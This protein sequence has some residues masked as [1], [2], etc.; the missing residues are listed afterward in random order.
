MKKYVK[1]LLAALLVMTMVATDAL[2]A[3]AAKKASDSH[4]SHI[5]MTGV[6]FSALSEKALE[7]LAKYSADKDVKSAFGKTVEGYNTEALKDTIWNAIFMNRESN[8]IN[9]EALGISQENADALTE[10]VLAESNAEEAVAYSVRK[11]SDGDATVMEVQIDPLYEAAYDEIDAATANTTS[12]EVAAASADDGVMLLTE[13]DDTATDPQEQTMEDAYAAFNKYQQFIDANPDYFGITVPYTSVKDDSNE[14]GGP[15]T[16]LV[17]IANQKVDYNNDGKIDDQDQGVT[18]LDLFKAGFVPASDL[19]QIINMFDM[20][21]QL[22]VNML[23]SELIATKDEA[24]AVVPGDVSAEQKLLILNDWLADKAT[25]DMASIMELDAPEPT[26]P[27]IYTQV[28]GA[29]QQQGLGESDAQALAQQLMGL[30][31]GN[32]FGVLTESMGNKGVCMSYTYAYAYLVQWAFSDVYKNKDGSWK[33]RLELN[34]I[35]N[36]KKET[37]EEI[38]LMAEEAVDETDAHE[39]TYKAK[40]TWSGEGTETSAKADIQCTECE[41]TAAGAYFGEVE[42]KVTAESVGATCASAGKT[43][44]TAT[45]EHETGIYTDKEEVIN[46]NEPAT[47]DH[48][49][50]ETATWS[51][52]DNDTA[53]AVVKCTQCGATKEETVEATKTSTTPSTCTEA[54]KTVYTATVTIDGKEYTNTNEVALELAEHTYSEETDKCTVCGELK[55]DHEHTYGDPVWSDW[56]EE[57]TTTATFT[58]TVCNEEETPENVNV[59]NVVTP[60]T[61]TEAG[62]T[63]YTASVEFGEESYTNPTTH[64]VDGDAATGHTYTEAPVWAWTDD[65]TATATY[66]CATCKEE[67]AVKAEVTSETTATCTEAG[68]TT[69]TATVTV[70]EEAD[71]GTKTVDTPALGHKFDE[72]DKCTV[73]GEKDLPDYVWDPSAAAMV[74][75]VRITY[76]TEVTMYGES[77]GNFDSDH[78][79]NAVKVDGQWYYVDPCYTDIY[80]ECMIRDRVETD[81]NMS[82]LYFMFSDTSARSLYEGNFSGIDTLYAD[83]AKETKY[84]DAW[85]AFARSPICKSGSKYYY[86]YDSTDMISLTSDSFNSYNQDT[87]YRLVYHDGTK[88]DTDAS[89]QTLIDFVEGEVRVVDED[90]KASMKENE[91]IATLYAE[92]EAYQ[93]KYPSIGISCDME[94]N[95]LYFNISNC[96]L[97][98][99][100][101]TCE[102]VKVFEYNEVTAER[103]LSMGLGGMAFT[104]VDPTE[105]AE[106]ETEGAELTT[107]TVENNPIASMTIKNGNMYVS[108]GTTIGFISGKESMSEEDK[109]I[110]YQFEETNYNPEYMEYVMSEGAM[111]EEEENDNDEFMWSANFVD[112]IEMS[113]I[114][115]EHTYEEVYVEA[116]CGKN[117]YTENRCTE[118]G[119]IEAG[120]REEIEDTALEHHFVKFDETYYTKTGDAWNT[121]TCYVCTNCKDAKD[122]DELEDTDHKG[123]AYTGYATAW[124]ED[125]TEATMDV[126]CEACHGVNYDCVISDDTVVLAEDLTTTD[127]TKERTTVVDKV[128]DEETGEEKEVKS[129]YW[130][131]TATVEYEDETYSDSIYV[132]REED[133]YDRNPFVDVSIDSWYIDSVLWAVDEGITTGVTETEFQPE[134]VCTRA[135]A[136]TFLWRVA[137][138][139]EPT[140]TE[141][142]FPDVS[143]NDWYYKAVLW[144]AEN[145]IT[146]G[147]SDGTFKPNTTCTRAEIVT[148]IWRMQ[149]KPEAKDSENSFPDV[150]EGM[151]YYDAVLWAA[152]EGITTGFNDGTFKPDNT[153][154]R[155]EIVTFLYRE[156]AE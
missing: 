35:P 4:A 32:Q 92:H 132:E 14:G 79:W 98:Y 106:E 16:S 19:I 114:T 56:T 141:N 105:E 5:E 133:K 63:T 21:N 100:V 83:Y 102:V 24:I 22:A 50:G 85:F 93:E 74:D 72:N 87:E 146:T 131:Y 48:T 38:A 113:H 76:D 86:F 91:L 51:W 145:G 58:C 62:Y 140:T 152:E 138:E 33:T 28:V 120:T 111:G 47:G 23:G 127:I 95:R 54:G 148:F 66:T 57:N 13:D 110:G 84:E 69:Y 123:H 25:F 154:T 2:P 101:E 142:P 129:Y 68:T 36:P 9:F 126:A 11:D 67:Y 1:Q 15:I 27:E 88:A 73:C 49:Y 97:Y 10:E 34:Y 155:A 134:E 37:T 117:A 45:V 65:N 44:Y 147:Y 94:G 135:E 55:P 59:S 12:T 136:V 7:F 71:T 64:K 137:G 30:W 124:N 70:R 77:Q 122:P 40:F 115:G 78:Y 42:A 125:Y 17:T 151:W 118:C 18:M 3:A 121:G 119:A 6:D 61:C 20:G 90:G 80:V 99:D 103:D 75:Y 153:C 39:H 143:E 107:L 116:T 60:P 139:E 82:H 156:F 31:G 144:A 108:V 104:V 46:E 96:I 53:T 109:S 52:M 128:V 112:V 130:I 41:A 149:D 43:V 150:T 29:L 89:F 81:G 8:V 26:T